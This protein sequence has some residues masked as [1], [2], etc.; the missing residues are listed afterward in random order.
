MNCQRCRKLLDSN[1]DNKTCDISIAYIDRRL[2]CKRCVN[3]TLAQIAP[4]IIE[5][6]SVECP[7]L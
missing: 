2:V 7:Y 5:H 1:P 4:D 6:L 3:Y